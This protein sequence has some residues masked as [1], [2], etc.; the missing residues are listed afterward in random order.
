[1]HQLVIRQ[2][3]LDDLHVCLA[4]ERLDQFG[5]VTRIDEQVI[6]SN[7]DIGS[8]FLAEH[9]GTPVGYASLNFLYASRIPL[10]SWWYVKPDFRGLGIGSMLLSEVEHYLESLG[11]DQL[12]VSECREIEIAR[13]RSAGL[14]EIG[15]LDLGVNEVEYF[16]VKALRKKYNISINWTC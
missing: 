14:R 13:H 2:A 9:S 6:K 12:L 16:F 10:F 5:R 15:S 4:F 3:I 8:V 1:M 11:F 7:I